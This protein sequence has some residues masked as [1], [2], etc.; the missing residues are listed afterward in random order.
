M[1]KPVATFLHFH[2][3][4]TVKMPIDGLYPSAANPKF[5][6]GQQKKFLGISKM[7]PQCF[8]DFPAF[9]SFV[10]SI[11]NS[12]KQHSQLHTS[13]KSHGGTRVITALH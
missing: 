9:L 13:F 3:H 7:F 8:K 4:Q 5:A 1:D 11:L 6:S 10:D 2:F 12:V